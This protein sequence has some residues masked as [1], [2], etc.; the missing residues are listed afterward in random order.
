VLFD[1]RQALATAVSADAFF[2]NFEESDEARKFGDFFVNSTQS[3][4]A[5]E[6]RGI[7]ENRSATYAAAIF[8]MSKSSMSNG[9]QRQLISAFL[10]FSKTCQFFKN[11]NA[12]NLYHHLARQPSGTPL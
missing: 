2:R 3:A 12:L 5:V 1:D 4:S 11:H 6:I 9:K 10:L 8:A 7:L